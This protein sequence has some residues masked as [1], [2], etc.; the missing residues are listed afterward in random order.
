MSTNNSRSGTLHTMHIVNGSNRLILAVC[1]FEVYVI[2]GIAKE[3]DGFAEHELNRSLDRVE[4]QPIDSI[5]AELIFRNSFE[6]M[7]FG[8]SLVRLHHEERD[9]GRDFGF[10]FVKLLGRV[11]GC[12][13]STP[14]LSESTSQ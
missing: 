6:R 10:P 2:C 13:H 12:H 8:A 3:E 11:E 14:A 1:I 5:E 4:P 9:R 7:R